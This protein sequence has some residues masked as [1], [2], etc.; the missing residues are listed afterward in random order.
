MRAEMCGE[1]NVSTTQGDINREMASSFL[2]KTEESTASIV[3][4]IFIKSEM[5]TLNR[6][7]DIIV[8]L[9]VFPPLALYDEDGDI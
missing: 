9:N 4:E 3:M 7:L 8:P 1:K 2:R 5:G 6:N